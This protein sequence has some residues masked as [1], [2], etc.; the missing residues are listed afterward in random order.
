MVWDLPLQADPGGPTPISYTVRRTRLRLRDTPFMGKSVFLLA[1]KRPLASG[2]GSLNRR[3]V[4]TASVRR[5]LRSGTCGRGQPILAGR[6][7]EMT[8]QELQFS[9]CNCPLIARAAR[10]Y[11]HI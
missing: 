11:D 2:G 4:P 8:V 9:H 7:A 1:S 5:W 6:H 10:I 3:L